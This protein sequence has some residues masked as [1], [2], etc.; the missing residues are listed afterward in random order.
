MMSI[1]KHTSNINL[2]I[3]NI[4]DS[5]QSG[6]EEIFNI[7]ESINKENTTIQSDIAKTKNIISVYTKEVED[8]KERE[9]N[10]RKK[11]L[12]VSSDFSHYT[13]E[14]IKNAY[15]KA[16]E[17]QE[18]LLAKKSDVTTVLQT[19][20]NLE[21]RIE[22]NREL[23]EKADRLL[24]KIEVLSEYIKVDISDSED[25]IKDATGKW[26][27]SQEKEKSR[28]SRD[29]HDGP[30]QTLASI[31]M[32]SDIIKRLIEK[33]S[34]KNTIYKEIEQLKHQLRSA[35]KEIRRI[36]YDLRP[37]SLD[38][39]GLIPSIQGLIAKAKE[40]YDINF[41]LSTGKNEPIK[42]STTKIICFR[43]LQESI[44]NILKHSHAKNVD[45]NISIGS[46]AII[47]KVADDGTGFNIKDVDSSKS[48]G[49]SSLKERILLA[50]GD[51]KII[52]KP[53]YGTRLEIKI[54]NKEDVYA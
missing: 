17:L 43:V 50:E 31:V 37:T 10:S 25:D 5:M 46:K 4:I 9:L 47:L 13:H 16:L 54:P 44:N 49:L 41:N 12:L 14:D 42:S 51:V 1:K 3:Q 32:K 40:D 30:A 6:K 29:I 39:L 33:D 48:F 38:E 7:T 53:N 52:S 11:L 23:T 18:K 21:K 35:I 8:L 24:N 22:K 28:I 36:I 2:A 45:I 26:I 19:L 15:E 27:L 20:E 34:P